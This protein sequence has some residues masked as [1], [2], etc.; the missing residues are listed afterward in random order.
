MSSTGRTP[1]ESVVTLGQLMLPDDANPSG[2]VH[3]GVVMKLVDT[4]AGLA[5]MRHA[6]SRCVTAVI[7]SM[8]FEAPVHIGDLLHLDARLT[9]TGRTS[10]EIE[11]IVETEDILAGTR[12][13]TS[14]AYVVYVALDANARPTPVPSLITTTDEERERWAAAERRRSLRLAHHS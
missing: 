9:W 5:A 13:R 8:T 2:D 6:R 11:V 4:A 3:G 7:D 14:T 1:A 12:I 10:M